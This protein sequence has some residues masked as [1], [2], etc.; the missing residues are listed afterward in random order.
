MARAAVCCAVFSLLSAATIAAEF[1]SFAHRK[2]Y[3]HVVSFHEVKHTVVSKNSGR[4]H[5]LAR[6]V[7]CVSSAV[8]CSTCCLITRRSISAA[9]VPPQHV[10]TY[11]S[12]AMPLADGEV[13]FTDPL[14]TFLKM[15]PGAIA[16]TG[17]K[18]T[19]FKAARRVI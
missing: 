16:I 19:L 6:R 7:A 14:K 9:S 8:R 4:S 12:V 10:T 5:V 3:P 18:H 17:P 11:R 15:P 13:V 2:T 1:P